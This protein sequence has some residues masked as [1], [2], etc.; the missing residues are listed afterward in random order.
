MPSNFLFL[1]DVLEPSWCLVSR[2]AAQALVTE[3]SIMVGDFRKN[4]RM[5]ACRDLFGSVSTKGIRHHAM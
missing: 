3:E 4:I 5:I 1:C 2:F